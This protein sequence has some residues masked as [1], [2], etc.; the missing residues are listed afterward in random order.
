MRLFRRTAPT[1]D[2]SDPLL[3]SGSGPIR[4]KHLHRIDLEDGCAGDGMGDPS[5]CQTHLTA[6]QRAEQRCDA[7]I[8]Y[9]RES[10]Q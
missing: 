6:W 7:V 2:Q 10:T 8:A 5:Y 4:I 1:T 3:G 9:R